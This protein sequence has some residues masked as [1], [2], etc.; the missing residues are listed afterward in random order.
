MY[1][2][3]LS[4]SLAVLLAGALS[5]CKTESPMPT[6]PDMTPLKT[7]AS[8][9]KSTPA[10]PAFAYLGRA[11][12]NRT[13]FW[14][15]FVMDSDGTHQTNLFPNGL[16]G[17]LITTDGTMQPTWSPSG[18]SIAF[19]VGNSTYT[20]SIYA[21]D[22]SVNSSGVP[23]SSNLRLIYGGSIH[24][25]NVAWS[26]TSTTGQIAFN[27]INGNTDDV[28]VVSQSG[29]TPVNVWHDTAGNGHMQSWSPDDSKLCFNR[30]VIVNGT[31][32]G[33]YLMIFNT[34]DQ[35]SSWSYVDS[36]WLP[37]ST[38]GIANG[39]EW[40][41][42]GTWGTTGKIAFTCASP[43]DQYGT[44]GTLYYVAP[45]TGATPTTNGVLAMYPTWDP[46]N[47]TLAFWAGSNCVYKATTFG[48]SSSEI[49][50]TY[51][52]RWRH[53]VWPN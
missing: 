9:S 26:N 19:C 28:W 17:H 32:T 15:V 30:R 35:G 8:G 10:H 3:L 46:T 40:S 22:I 20:D 1:K 29:G 50:C 31:V 16:N 14:S 24:I 4:L 11:T 49:T 5:S 51:C 38:Y 41:R 7:S 44:S 36:I 18:N 25:V 6:G 37:I 53:T 33:R 52:P 27:T 43:S 2:Q 47:A 39:V 34:T 45:S 21:F 42:G 13:T 48:S 23:V 12:V